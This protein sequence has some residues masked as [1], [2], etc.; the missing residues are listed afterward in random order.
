[1]AGLAPHSSGLETL[2]QRVQRLSTEILV[3]VKVDPGKSKQTIIISRTDSS[4]RR[5]S[6]LCVA[7][8]GLPPLARISQNGGRSFQIAVRSCKTVDSLTDTR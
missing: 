2:V 1:L 4:S 8:A 5:T 6:P 7:T 3:G